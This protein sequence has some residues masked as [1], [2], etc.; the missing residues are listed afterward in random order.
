MHTSPYPNRKALQ[1]SQMNRMLTPDLKDRGSYNFSN[2]S[3]KRKRNQALFIKNFQH[4][5]MSSS[6]RRGILV[7][8][9][10]SINKSAIKATH[11]S[12][13][14]KLTKSDQ[15]FS[16]TSNC[17][18]SVKV[19]RQRSTIRPNN[20]MIGNKSSG[21]FYTQ[22]RSNNNFSTRSS[23]TTLNSKMFM[24]YSHNAG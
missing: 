19:G 4:S 2:R 23:R 20:S 17:Y 9:N 15:V 1:R 7:V 21:N 22:I 11:C 10:N 14:S 5:G 16:E 12:S 6:M 18:G 24:N 8:R 13:S 3:E